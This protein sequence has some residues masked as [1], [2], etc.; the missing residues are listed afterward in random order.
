MA[1]VKFSDGTA[2]TMENGKRVPV[3]SI[4]ASTNNSCGKI[5][6][7]AGTLTYKSPASGNYVTINFDDIAALL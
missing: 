7:C 2:W 4:E 1:K 5:D 3:D 6:W